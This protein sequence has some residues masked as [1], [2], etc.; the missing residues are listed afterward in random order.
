MTG[1][2]YQ[3]RLKMVFL[4][5]DHYLR[6]SQGPFKMPWLTEIRTKSRKN[7]MPTFPRK[8]RFVCVDFGY[9]VSYAYLL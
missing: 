2:I 5:L 3:D 4:G 6:F 7:M 8:S 1:D 9:L